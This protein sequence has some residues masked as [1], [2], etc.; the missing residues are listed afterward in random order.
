L[1]LKNDREIIIVLLIEVWKRGIKNKM[2][3]IVE[4]I[5]K[6]SSEVKVRTRSTVCRGE[7]K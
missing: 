2:M 3:K 6:K 7:W 1:T 5:E 4:Y